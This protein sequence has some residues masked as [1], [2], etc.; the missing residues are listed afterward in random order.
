MRRSCGAG[1]GAYPPF[2]ILYVMSSGIMQSLPIRQI[3]WR[4]ATCF[5]T[6]GDDRIY[7]WRRRFIGFIFNF[8]AFQIL[9]TQNGID[10][11]ISDSSRGIAKIHIIIHAGFLLYYLHLSLYLRRGLI[12]QGQFH[13]I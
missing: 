9:F 10:F 5:G 11:V 6:I 13:S 1:G 8:R 7:Y 2:R 4:F 12:V 3:I